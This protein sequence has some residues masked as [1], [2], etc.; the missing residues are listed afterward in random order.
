MKLAHY[1]VRTRDL[2]ASQRF[3][4]EVLGLRAG[5]RPPFRF[6]G[7]WLY[8]TG[9]ESHFGVVHLVGGGADDF[10]G[11]GRPQDGLDHIAFAAEDWTSQ[12]ARLETMGIPFEQRTV[13]RLGLHQVFLADPSGIV[14]ELNYPVAA[15]EAP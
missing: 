13:P 5:S 2:K 7:A 9:D 11:A 4:A 6:P 12:R 1:A 3:Y 15:A 10:L 14:I 8:A